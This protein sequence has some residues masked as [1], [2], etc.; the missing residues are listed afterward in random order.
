MNM[1][2]FIHLRYEIVILKGGGQMIS[3]DIMSLVKN[4]TE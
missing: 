1:R 3:Q 2:L 4:C